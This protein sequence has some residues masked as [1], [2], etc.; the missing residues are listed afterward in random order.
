MGE[1]VSILIPTYN[2]EKLIGKSLES[3]LN[4][5]HKNL[6]IIIYDDGSTDGTN[7]VI[8]SYNDDR[9]KHI[10]SGKNR[11][12]Q[13]ARNALLNEVKTKYS[14]WHDSDDISNY[15]RIEKQLKFMKDTE[16][17]LCGTDYIPIGQAGNKKRIISKW[18][19]LIPVNSIWDREPIEDSIIESIKHPYG[20]FASTMFI[21]K[22]SV[23]F[24]NK[25]NLG[26]GDSVW[27]QDMYKYNK[28]ERPIINKILYY[29]MYHRN[30]ISHW[31]KKASHNREWYRRMEDENRI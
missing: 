11:G 17:I 21:T 20:G 13:K 4:Q 27:L 12:V 28:T 3:I 25:R 7:D 31:K 6:E 15:W 8:K 19:S 30:S 2:R 18:G 14:A 1:K 22:N 29:V 24:N 23:P 26:G 10:I 16:S 5:T 9:I